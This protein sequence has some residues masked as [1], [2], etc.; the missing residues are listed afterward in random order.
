MVE[1]SVLQP[2]DANALPDFEKE[3]SAAPW[4][5][6][7]LVG[8]MPGRVVMASYE[9]L[10]ATGTPVICLSPWGDANPI[11]LPCVRFRD[12]VVHTVIVA[13]GGTAAFV[14]PAL[15]PIADI[16]GSSFVSH[17]AVEVIGAAS[18]TAITETGNWLVVEKP[19]E[20]M[21]PRHSKKLITTSVKTLVI[22][23]KYKHIVDDA[24]LGYFR[25][26]EHKDSSMISNVADYFK[27]ENGWF[28]PYLF[29]TSRRPAIPR[30]MK[31]DV[32]FAHGP[33]L[34]GDYEVAERL[35]TESSIALHFCV[36]PP[37]KPIQPPTPSTVS[38][39]LQ[40]AQD[41]LSTF[42]KDAKTLSSKMASPRSLIAS[43]SSDKKPSTSEVAGVF[44]FNNDATGSTPASTTTLA[45]EYEIVASDI[46]P[47]ST[48]PAPPR[49]MVILLLGIKPHRLGMWSSS[50]RP[51]ES[52]MQYLLLNGCPA[53]VGPVKPGSPLIS[54]DTLTLEH[55]HD[56]AK[57]GRGS[58]GVVRVIFEYVSLCVDWERVI[59]PEMDQEAAPA[60]TPAPP[61]VQGED[62]GKLVEEPTDVDG[63]KRKAVKDAIEL[64]VEA[65]MRSGESKEVKDKV[66]ADRAGIVMFRLP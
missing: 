40:N 36:P 4:I 27:I 45:P 29:S 9:T 64:L 19:I 18:R 55:L 23:V 14:T 46:N 7:K 65:C 62:D 2:T 11:Q 53:I 58:A 8:S 35:L 49:R 12:L 39:A 28:S 52:V 56:M 50:L 17:I 51:S 43:L 20:L 31:A 10:R 33:F 47:T 16:G 60:T 1:R 13:T 54:W 37:P 21:L 38:G 3:D 15:V 26:P 5:M 25:S 57:S 30:T 59:I 22:T 42:T 41:K 61:D 44:A 48:E 66:D 24:A 32:I 34:T 6:R 63:R